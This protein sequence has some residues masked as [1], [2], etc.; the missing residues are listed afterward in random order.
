MKETILKNV[1]KLRK[2]L[3]LKQADFAEKIGITQTNYSNFER[4]RIDISISRLEKI[5]EVFN[6]PITEL[7]SI[8]NFEFSNSNINEELKNENTKLK[9]KIAFIENIIK[10]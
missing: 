3:G 2:N 5:A 9:Q 8:Q 7:L 6:V 10:M 1:I 4:G